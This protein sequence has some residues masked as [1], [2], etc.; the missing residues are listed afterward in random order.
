MQENS[1]EA[2]RDDRFK[3][4]PQTVLNIEERE[5]RNSF[6]WRGQFS[7]QLVEALISA[8]A[9]GYGTILDPFVGSGTTIC[10]A[11]RKQIGALGFEI[12]PAAAYLAKVYEFINLTAAERRAAISSVSK[13][14]Q[15]ATLNA[16]PLFAKAPLSKSPGL[17][18]RLREIF[19]GAKNVYQ[20]DLLCAWA[21]TLDDTVSLGF[22]K[23]LLR[24]E[25]LCRTVESLPYSSSPVVV[26]VADARRLPISA[27][28]I[29]FVLTSPPYVNVFN[30]HQNHREAVEALG[31]RVLEVARSEIGSNRKHRQNRFLTV[32]QYCLDLSAVLEE[33]RRVCKPNARLVFVLG[34][35]S[36]VRKTRFFNGDICNSIA[37]R[38]VGFGLC[39]RQERVFTNRFGQQIHEDILVYER[40]SQP[41]FRTQPRDIALE[42]LAEARTRAPKDSL[43]D[44]E[45]AMGSIDLVEQSPIFDGQSAYQP[46]S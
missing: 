18:E 27:D 43:P 32:I 33:V 14:V 13:L 2:H 4:L 17:W 34:R 46:M 15:R 45:C 39:L 12:N 29:D 23:P 35:E 31:W 22:E 21:V 37:T 26:K 24:W 28:S 40:G 44:L 36:N 9:P 1:S 42:V 25:Q 5:R 7:P 38:T 30:Y 3:P 41:A 6:A 20:T 8:Y 10:E 11:G 19:S 16:S